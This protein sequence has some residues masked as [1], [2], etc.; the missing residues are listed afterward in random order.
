MCAEN[1]L[2]YMNDI[3]MMKSYKIFVFLKGS[4]VDKVIV[5][6]NA[7]AL[8]CVTSTYVESLKGYATP[9]WK[10]YH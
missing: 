1:K 8:I 4:E 2:I 3:F 5:K 7:T 6:P 9:K 10:C